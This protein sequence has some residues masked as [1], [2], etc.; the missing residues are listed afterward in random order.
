M[1]IENI[2]PED[3]LT[4]D[5]LH[6]ELIKMTKTLTDYF[7]KNNLTYFLA[8]GTLLGAIRHKGIIPWDDDVDFLMPRPD[9]DKFREMTHNNPISKNLIVKS[10]L[11]D[12]AIYPFCKVCNIN[13]KVKEELWEMSDVSYLWIDIHPMDGLSENDEDNVKLYKKIHSARHKLSLRIMEKSKIKE[14]SKSKLKALI[15]PFYK[16]LLDRVPIRVLSQKIE[17]LSLTYDY[18]T[19][20]YI[21]CAMWGYGPQERVLKEDTLKIVKVD[22]EGMKLDAFSCWD[23]YLHNL[24]GDYMTLPPEEKRHVHLAKIFRINNIEEN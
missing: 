12:D 24:Y 13:F 11:D 14:E 23:E 6:Q 3:C 10:I 16:I 15:K 4:L 20:K 1:E 19:C 5:E 17:D 21:G 22:F 8:G 2:K 18:N 9:Y 7:E